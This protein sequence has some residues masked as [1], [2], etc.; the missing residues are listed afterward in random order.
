M[1]RSA[2]GFVP[3]TLSQKASSNCCEEDELAAVGAATA[4]ALDELDAGLPSE[5]LA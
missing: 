5:A 2:R 4:G 1:T 3:A